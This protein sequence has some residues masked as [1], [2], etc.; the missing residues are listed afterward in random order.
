M[1]SEKELMR[2]ATRKLMDIF[3]TQYLRDNYKNIIKSYG[4]IDDNIYALFVGI[5]S[6]DDLPGRK[7]ERHGW[8]V[9]G[10]VNV[11]ATTGKVLD[12]VYALE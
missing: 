11:N 12:T 6:I 5:K 1:M 4:K 10:Q 8:V 3:G 7:A 9:Y 2:I